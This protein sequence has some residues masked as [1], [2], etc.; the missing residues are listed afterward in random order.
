MRCLMNRCPFKYLGG[1]QLVLVVAPHLNVQDAFKFWTRVRKY[2]NL[3][4]ERVYRLIIL[5]EKNR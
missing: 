3:T 4:L 2:Y 5:R 1:G